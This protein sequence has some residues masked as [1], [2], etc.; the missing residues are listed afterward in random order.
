MIANLNTSSLAASAKIGMQLLQQ[1]DSQKDEKSLQLVMPSNEAVRVIQAELI[2]I[3]AKA[4]QTTVSAIPIKDLSKSQ[5]PM[6]VHIRRWIVSWD[7]ERQ[8]KNAELTDNRVEQNFDVMNDDD[9]DID[10]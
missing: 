8:G 10:D 7:L 6:R 2:K 5:D 4:Y 3:Y 1:W 9:D